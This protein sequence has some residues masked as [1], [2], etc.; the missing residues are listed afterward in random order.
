MKKGLILL[1]VFALAVGTVDVVSAAPAGKNSGKKS[2]R[3]TSKSA[4][5]L[6]REKTNA[7]AKLSTVERLLK[8]GKC[9]VNAKNKQGKTALMIAA[10]GTNLE[11][12]KKLVA[13]GSDLNATDKSGKTALALA[14]DKKIKEFLQQKMKS[15]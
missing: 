1:A 14:K 10:V 7:K 3:N 11:L 6:Q 8:S 5:K 15:K 13:A 12:V 9:D 2:G 4:G